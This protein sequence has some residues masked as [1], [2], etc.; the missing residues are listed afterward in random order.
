LLLIEHF[1]APSPVHGLGVFS[2]GFVPAGT[3]V[4]IFHPLIDREIPKGDLSDLPPHVV[5][6]I[7]RHA[8][9]FP[10]R[11]IF[12]LS[13]DG[14]HFMNHADSPNIEDRVDEMFACKDI[15]SGEE[16]FIDYRAIKVL[17]FEPIPPQSS[18]SDRSQA[19]SR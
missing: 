9:Y 15:H 5:S 12:R 7:E 6:L 13:G 4:W 10:E 3:K 19:V 8:E 2:S 11:E 1:V 16:L 17:V 14:D 18:G